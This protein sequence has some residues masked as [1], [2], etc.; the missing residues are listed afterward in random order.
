MI[1]INDDRSNLHTVGWVLSRNFSKS[2]GGGTKTKIEVI[3]PYSLQ[4]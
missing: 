3:R 4:F 2:A 1:A